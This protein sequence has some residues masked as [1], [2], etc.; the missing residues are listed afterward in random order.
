MDGGK[1]TMKIFFITSSCE[2]KNKPFEMSF[3]L[4]NLSGPIIENLK[5]TPK[6]SHIFYSKFSLCMLTS[7]DKDF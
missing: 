4:P 1:S 5:K 2:K 3:N 7:F 6:Q